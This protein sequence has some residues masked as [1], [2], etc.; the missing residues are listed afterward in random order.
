[1]F[2]FVLVGFIL[3]FIKSHV[4]HR[5]LTQPELKCISVVWSKHVSAGPALPPSLAWNTDPSHGFP[6]SMT[7]LPISTHG[8]I[9]RLWCNNETT[10]WHSLDWSPRPS[11]LTADTPRHRHALGNVFSQQSILE[12]CC[13]ISDDCQFNPAM[14]TWYLRLSY[15]R[16]RRREKER[17]KGK[18][19]VYLIPLPVCLLSHPFY[20]FSSFRRNVWSLCWLVNCVPEIHL[21][22]QQSWKT[23]PCRAQ[24]SQIPMYRWA[25][26]LHLMCMVSFNYSRFVNFFY[27]WKKRQRL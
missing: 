25:P 2:G 11:D 3:H 24:S 14:Y 10:G 21:E 12:S 16:K 23:C 1:M 8:G 22:S 6:S 5:C 9:F 13:T 4:I 19:T 15:F 18:A 7:L 26:S 17:S 20:C 27:V